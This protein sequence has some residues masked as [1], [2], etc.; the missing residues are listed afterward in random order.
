MFR[1]NTII[2][3]S[4]GWSRVLSRVL[5]CHVC[6]HV[7]CVVTC[8]VLSRVLC[9]FRHTQLN[10]FLCPVICILCLH[11][12]DPHDAAWMGIPHNCLNHSFKFSKQRSAKPL[13]PCFTLKS[14]SDDIYV[15]RRL[16]CFLWTMPT[17]ANCFACMINKNICKNYMNDLN[18]SVSHLML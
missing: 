5:C 18:V 15:N 11:N 14:V 12:F 4:A 13:Y 2:S 16:L 7:C 8:V 9:I 3:S 6:C 10:Q 17:N 1:Q